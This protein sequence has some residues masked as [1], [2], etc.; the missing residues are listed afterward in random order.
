[1]T[2][3]KLAGEQVAERQELVREKVG[4]KNNNNNKQTK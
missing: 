2:K 1:L 3:E 4:C